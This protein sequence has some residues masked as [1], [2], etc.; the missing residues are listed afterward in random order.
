MLSS[1][2]S[3]LVEGHFRVDSKSRIE[4]FLRGYAKPPLPVHNAQS[5]ASTVPVSAWSLP[6]KKTRRFNAAS[7]TR[8]KRAYWAE[9]HCS[10]KL[11]AATR[12]G[13]SVPRFHGPNRRSAAI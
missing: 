8:A 1:L 5:V 12:A 11:G 4:P 9:F 10:R 2:C 13:A 7:E 3:E 6:R